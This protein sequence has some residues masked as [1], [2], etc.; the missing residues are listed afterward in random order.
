[1][2]AA[3]LGA[4]GYAGQVLLRI[5]SDHPEV[6][7]IMASSSSQ[8]GTKVRDADPGLPASIEEK[9]HGGVLVPP[10]DVA[11]ARDVDVVF[12][13]LPHL[14]SAEVCAPLLGRTVVVDLSAD[15]R[16]RDPAV[17]Q[18]A[19]GVPVPRPTSSRKRSTAWQSG[20]RMPSGTPRSSPTPAATPRP[21]SCRSFP[22]PGKAW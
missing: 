6:R 9:V 22:S 19:Y 12:S 7:S 14:K 5:L 16:L 18:K 3:V 4:T 1:M 20:T 8:A 11:A 13:A 2:K 21:P 15:F 17:F 10:A